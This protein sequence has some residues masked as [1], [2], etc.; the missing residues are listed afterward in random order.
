MHTS[1]TTYTF[2]YTHINYYT[3]ATQA[4]SLLK[5]C[6]YMDKDKHKCDTLFD[7]NDG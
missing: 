6:P 1:M 4:G 3:E 2:Y 7:S 5:P